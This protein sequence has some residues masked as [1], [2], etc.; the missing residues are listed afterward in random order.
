MDTHNKIL[1][2]LDSNGNPVAGY[3]VYCAASP[4]GPYSRVSTGLVTGTGFVDISAEVGADA[5][6]GGTYYY[7]V[8]SEDVDADESVQ[9]L[10]VSPATLGGSSGSGGGGCFIGLVASYYSWNE[11]YNFAIIMGITC[12]GLLTLLGL[13]LFF[14]SAL[15]HRIKNIDNLKM[16]VVHNI[17]CY[18]RLH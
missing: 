6:G 7:G 13:G 12:I 2:A 3:H 9:S 18:F 8:T 16:I 10:G 15:S 14:G 1:A 17:Y 4:A 5:G 11:N